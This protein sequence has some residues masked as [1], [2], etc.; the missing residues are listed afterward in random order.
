[1]HDS[2]QT[3]EMKTKI[4]KKTCEREN[5]AWIKEKEKK[6]RERYRN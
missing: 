5:T 2:Q 1:M 3:R 6:T 4:S